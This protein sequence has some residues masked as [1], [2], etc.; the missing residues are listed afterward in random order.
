MSPANGETA[1]LW[2]NPLLRAEGTAL[3]SAHQAI[4]KGALE[5]ELEVD[6]IVG[7]RQVPFEPVFGLLD[8]PNV[9]RTLD[10]HHLTM[11]DSVDGARA[12]SLAVR[13]ASE[14]KRVLAMIPNEQLS[15]AIN[16]AR[17]ALDAPR[18]AEGGVVLLLEDNPYLVRLASPWQAARS[19]GIPVVAPDGIESLRD[20]IEHAFRLANAGPRMAAIVAHSAVLRS[21]DSPR[22]RANR[23]TERVEQVA[24]L[25]RARRGA[26]APEGDDVLRVVRR[27]ELNRV[28]A[29]P[30]PGEREPIAFIT[31][32]PAATAIHHILG[33]FGLEGRVPVLDLGC[34]NPMD[35]ALLERFELLAW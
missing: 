33:E 1:A 16:A 28:A 34:T 25:L 5:S 4:L 31:V 2:S 20:G 11:T 26:R 30:S 7:P 17:R 10:A 23:V 8:D 9:A 15:M 18:S 19:I 21:L 12:V 32:G 22:L 13:A 27:L 6:A 29:L 3:L 24:A 35:E 14:G